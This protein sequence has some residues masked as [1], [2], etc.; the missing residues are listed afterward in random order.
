MDLEKLP[1]PA[2]LILASVADGPV[3]GYAIGKEVERRTGGQ[4]RLGATTLYRVVRQLL[5]SGY[6]A[7]AA[8]PRD[9]ENTD[10]RRRY[11]RITPAGRRALET[12]VRRLR[13]V[14]QATESAVLPKGS[15][16]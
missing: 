15:R 6:L 5:E 9:A 7:E 12:E 16:S 11:F 1:A 13:S 3:H 8:A 10:E 2:V 14:L 4:V